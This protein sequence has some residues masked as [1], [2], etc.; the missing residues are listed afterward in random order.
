[1]R[2]L[3]TGFLRAYIFRPAY[4]VEPREE[5]SFS[6]RLLRTPYPS[7]RAISPNLMIS[8][9]DLRRAMVDVT[10]HQGDAE[11]SIFKNR[12]IRA[13]AASP[14]SARWR[15]AFYDTERFP[16]TTMDT[17]S[18]MVL[19]AFRTALLLAG[20]TKTAEFAVLEG[21]DDCESVSDRTLLIETVRSALRRRT[22]SPAVPDG[23]DLLPPELRRLLG[24]QPVFRDCFILR[25]LV[26]LP[27]EACAEF[28]K[29]S[30]TEY[31]DAL[32]GALTQLPLLSSFKAARDAQE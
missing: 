23:S 29:M 11:V 25:I 19:T 5:P 31:E 4:P 24:L 15:S 10:L 28:L 1:M 2:F 3:E 14:A 26:Q 30:I 17:T 22:E 7:F 21:I 27:P 9:N 20:A 16:F 13:M 12:D 32:Y 8:A 6:Y 18:R